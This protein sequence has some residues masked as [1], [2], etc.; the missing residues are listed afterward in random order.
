MPPTAKRLTPDH[1]RVMDVLYWTNDSIDT[2]SK[3]RGA[4]V[5]DIHACYPG[6][7]L[8]TALGE[9]ANEAGRVDR[10][11]QDKAH[12]EREVPHRFVLNEVCK[13]QYDRL[14][15]SYQHPMPKAAPP[16]VPTKEEQEAAEEQAAKAPPAAP[17]GKSTAGAAP[18]FQ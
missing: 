9:L 5:E 17:K 8:S 6:S 4:T 15:H 14:C 11:M 7:D 16:R 2:P 12:L 13:K 1:F 18:V 3:R 10:V